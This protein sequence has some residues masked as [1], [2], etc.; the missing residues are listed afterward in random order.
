MDSNTINFKSIYIYFNEQGIAESMFVNGK[1]QHCLKCYFL[2]LDNL[3][4]HSC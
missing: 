2:F 3:Q 1:L 4:H